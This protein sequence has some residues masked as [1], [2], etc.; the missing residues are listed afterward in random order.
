MLSKLSGSVRKI[1]QH[2]VAKNSFALFFLQFANM[3]APLIILPYLT[4]VLGIDN[5]GIVMLSMSACAIGVII[6]DFGFNL[7]AT[8]EISKNRENHS[9]INEY[10]GAVFIVKFFLAFVFCCGLLLF[11]SVNNPELLIYIG[12]NIFFQAFLPTWFF[13]GVEKMKGITIYM[14]IAKVVYI[15]LVFL[16]VNKEADAELVVL[17]FAVSNFVAVVISL[18]FIYLNGY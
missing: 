17:F 18:N 15:A 4:R 14:L 13:Q 5:F 9:Y 10:I 6:T 12:L 8:Y 2:S 16:F 7:S 1:V 11:N 3:L